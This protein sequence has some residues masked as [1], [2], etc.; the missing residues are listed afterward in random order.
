MPAQ[1]TDRSRGGSVTRTVSR[2][3]TLGVAVGLAV[4]GLAAPS[5]AHHNT[6]TGAVSCRDGG[7]WLVTW[8]VVNSEQ[9]AEKITAS[10]RAVVPVGTWLGPAE[11]KSVTET[12]TSKP[13]SPLTLT[14]SAKWTNGV[15]ATSSGAISVAAFSDACNVTKVD[16]P[17]IPVVDECGPGNAHY[18]TV[19]TGPWTAEIGRA[20]V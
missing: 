12:V 2:V 11:A 13:G 4:I 7:G 5:S 9:R 14:L 8:R 10:N 15:T 17:T 1:H 20:H 18:G 6:I 3:V 19:P 16:A